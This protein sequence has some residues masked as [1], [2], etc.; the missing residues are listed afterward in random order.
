MEP[1]IISRNSFSVLGLSRRLAPQDQN[2]QVFKSIWSEFEV[3]L[4]EMRV[5]S[6]DGAFYGLSFSGDQPGSVDYVAAMAVDPSTAIR[7]V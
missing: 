3:R 7:R 1:E 4:E 6:I 5:H 2:E